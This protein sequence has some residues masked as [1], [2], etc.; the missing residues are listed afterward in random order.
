MPFEFFS[1]RRKQSQDLDLINDPIKGLI[2][3]MSAPLMLS[4]FV[5]SSYGITDMLFASRLGSV[6]VA[7]IAFI[8]PLFVLLQAFTTGITRGGVSII[9]SLLGKNHR[10]EAS[11]Y[12]CQLRWLMLLLSIVITLSF[13][14]LLPL[15][16]R[17]SNVPE[18]LSQQSQTYASVMFL[19]MPFVLFSRLYDGFFRTQGKVKVLSRI[20][21]FS[22]V[23]NAV[24]NYLFLTFTSLEVQGL[25]FANVI[26]SILSLAIQLFIF[27]R[28]AQSFDLTWR[29]DIDFPTLVLWIKLF[30]VGIPLSVSQ[31]SSH[32]GF[33]LLNI[34]IVQFG[35]HAVA[36]FAIGNRINSLMF[37]P[38]K[39]MGSAMVPLLAQ[40]IGKGSIDRVR[41]AIH[42]SL[43]YSLIIGVI[44][45]L[46]LFVMK[47]PI[48][49]YLDNGDDI[50]YNHIINYVGL[51]GWTVIAWALL[52]NTQATFNA[53]QKTVFS[54]KI[55][56]VR[57]WGIRIPGVLLF[58]YMVPTVAEYGIWYTMFISNIIA[59]VI[60]IMYFIKWIPP[61]LS[62][63]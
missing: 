14:V 38:C 18:V 33:L 34:L 50:T 48:A 23:T 31:A 42:F 27:T 20:A 30:K 35:H 63:M 53:F 47:Y 25:A 10:A 26:S 9:A 58:L 32:F 17:L 37:S 41:E 39:Q 46:I 55:E 59:L 2:H 54:M 6:E 5:S 61:L 1:K 12:A 19:S 8:T 3:N 13:V 21:I 57:L 60:A 7:A 49:C 44:A 24:L 52:Q 11:A 40:N 36:A 43:L 29:K 22:I 4:G 56:M 51:V 28:S 15:L 62:N 16:L 45:A